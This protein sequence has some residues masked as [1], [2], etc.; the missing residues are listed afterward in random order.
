[1]WA[2][3]SVT[4]GAGIVPVRP[5]QAQAPVIVIA[6][7]ACAYG[8]RHQSPALHHSLLLSGF[9]TSRN[10][11]VP[12]NAQ[13]HI[14]RFKLSLMDHFPRHSPAARAYFFVVPQM[15]SNMH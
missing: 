6:Q 2:S 9:C 14:D 5:A 7:H 11:L 15:D 3:V 8:C 4:D 10:M 12:S 13:H 1:M